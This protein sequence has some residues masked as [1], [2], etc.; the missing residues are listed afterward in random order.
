MS[1]FRN[2]TAAKKV[3]MINSPFSGQEYLLYDFNLRTS[4]Y[5]AGNNFLYLDTLNIGGTQRAVWQD[6]S[7][8]PS[9]TGTTAIQ[10]HYI[11]GIGDIG[12]FGDLG[13]ASGQFTDPATLETYVYGAYPVLQ[14]FCV[15]GQTLYPDTNTG[16]C[17]ALGIS[18][19]HSSNI[20]ARIYPG[21]A[22]TIIHL[23]LS[24]LT[25]NTELI[26]RDMLGRQVYSSTISDAESV[27]NISD[28]TSG[29]YTW[30]LKQDNLLRKTGKIIKD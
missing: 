26:M 22:H 12:G 2:D 6:S 20:D 9:D 28:L 30:Y 1:A 21:P 17:T 27:H 24:D 18:T 5:A 23:S 13:F 29:V 19:V 25:E 15:C 16:I 8:Y 14:S 7:Y 10:M 11:E 4:D 3:Y